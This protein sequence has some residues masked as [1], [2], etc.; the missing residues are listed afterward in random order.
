MDEEEEY[1]PG[2]EDNDGEGNEALAQ[3]NTGPAQ[4]NPEP[5]QEPI[6]E[7]HIEESPERPIEETKD[8]NPV[9]G[10][11]PETQVMN[12]DNQQEASI[13]IAEEFTPILFRMIEAIFKVEAPK[14]T[15]KIGLIYLAKILNFYPEFTDLY[16]QIL[17]S[18]PDNIRTSVVD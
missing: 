16:L 13:K 11:E 4:E 14:A 15:L 7:N 2:A 18:V 3:D 1:H 17:L 5:V 9:I 8:P 10:E 6:S 12:T